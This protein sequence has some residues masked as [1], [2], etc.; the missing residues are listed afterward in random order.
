MHGP[1]NIRASSP[2]M[3]EVPQSGGVGA[4][5]RRTRSLAGPFAFP[6][7]AFRAAPY[8]SQRFAL[9]HLSHQGKGESLSILPGR[10]CALK[11]DC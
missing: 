8:P 10:N 11:E 3:G 9:S 6:A 1:A 5:R 4:R 2:L 7:G